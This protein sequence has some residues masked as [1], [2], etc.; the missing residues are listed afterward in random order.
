MIK[1]CFSKKKKFDTPPDIFFYTNFFKCWKNKKREEN[2][3]Y[4]KQIPNF[5]FFQYLKNS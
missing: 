3:N 1:K 2:M 4:W 5:F